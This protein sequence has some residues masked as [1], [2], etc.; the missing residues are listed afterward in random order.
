MSLHLREVT[1]TYGKG[2]NAFHALKPVNVGINPGSTVAIVGKS[3]SG[4][5]TLL[6]LMV[7]LDHPTA[8]EILF[9]G[10]NIFKD[11]KTDA[12]RGENVGIIF[13]Q[14]FLQ[15]K[16]SVVD[17]VSLPL[18]LR[19]M[20]KRKR[21]AEAKEAL[22]LVGL[23]DKAKNKANDLSGGQKQRVAIARAIVTKPAI[24]VADEPTGNLDSENGEAVERLLFQLNQQLNTTLILVTHDEDLASRC[25]RIIRLHDGKVVEDTAKN[26][27]GSEVLAHHGTTAAKPQTPADRRPPGTGQPTPATPQFK[28]MAP[29]SKPLT[30]GAHKPVIRSGMPAGGMSA[31]HSLKSVKPVH[32]VPPGMNTM[33]ASPHPAKP[34]QHASSQ[35][36]GG[37]GTNKPVSRSAR[38][39]IQ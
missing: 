21:V 33:P 12:W 2:D 17:N 37:S 26:P 10:K 22:R 5:S 39:V 15:P 16:D 29:G 11:Y 24:L 23:L 19:G 30:A 6:H 18:K 20:G 38:R 8:G 13:Q 36:Q 14:F 34:M 27:T 3:G 31:P 28:Q 35:A 4:K 9:N 25:Q 1:K 7:G 32:P